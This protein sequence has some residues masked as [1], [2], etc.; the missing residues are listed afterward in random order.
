MALYD[1]RVGGGFPE[2]TTAC[3]GTG[4]QGVPPGSPV[5]ATP[6]SVTFNGAGN[7]AQPPPPAKA[8]GCKRGFV[9]KHGKCV[10]ARTIRC[11]RGFVKKH[12]KCVRAKAEKK[13]HKAGTKRRTKR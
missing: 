9:K 1:A 6:S 8:A 12:N 4:C 5:F 10:K 11:R 3:T 13:G 2:T 7:F